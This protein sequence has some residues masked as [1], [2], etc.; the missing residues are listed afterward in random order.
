MSGIY[1]FD[2]SQNLYK[3]VPD[4]MIIDN[5]QEQELNGLISGTCKLK[6]S[7]DLEDAFFYG[8]K[9]EDK[10]WLFSIKNAIKKENTITFKGVHIMYDELKGKVVRDLRPNNK[11]VGSVCTSIL[12]GTGWECISHCN[13]RG[14]TNFYYQSSLS[15]LY[16]VVQKFGV[17]FVPVVKFS[18]GKIVAKQIHI[19]SKLG[20]DLGKVFAYKDNLVQVVAETSSDELFTAFIGRGKGETK[21][22]DS[23]KATGGYGRKIKFDSIDYKDTIDDI[24]VHSPIGSDMIEIKEATKIYGYPDGSPRICTVDFDDIEDKNELAIATFKFAI[25]HSRPR[26][27]LRAKGHAY[28]RIGIGEIVTIIGPMD[29]RFKTRIFKLKKDFL[30]KKI[31]DFE[32]GDKIVKSMSD[33]LKENQ[34]DSKV[35]EINEI[36]FMDSIFTMIEST[37]YNED[38]YQY[39]LKPG[40]KYKLPAGLYSFNKPIDKNPDKVIYFGAGKLMIANSKKDDGSW[41][42]RVALN[43]DSVNADEIRAGILRGGKV[44]WN[45]EDGTFIIGND[46]TDY[47]MY[48]DGST[49]HL[50]NVDIDLENNRTIQDLKNKQGM[51]DKEIAARKE[52]IESAK[53]DLQEA[54]TSL[55]GSISEVSNNVGDLDNRLDKQDEK[56]KI[57]SK[58]ILD[59]KTNLKITDGKIQTSVESINKTVEEKIHANIDY[60]DGKDRDL[61]TYLNNN[62]ST[63]SQTDDKISSEVGK[64]QI[65]TDEK[66]RLGDEEVRKY[67]TKNYTTITQTDEKIEAT[68][69]SFKDDMS[70]YESRFTQLK[71]EISLEVSSSKQ[72]GVYKNLIKYGWKWEYGQGIYWYSDR[73]DNFVARG[74]SYYIESN[75]DLRFTSNKEADTFTEF[76]FEL[77]E[78][79]PGIEEYTLICE[80]S[81]IKNTVQLP[82]F[83][84]DDKFNNFL[85]YGTEINKSDKVYKL[86]L[87]DDN[88]NNI[89]YQLRL[90]FKD[91]Q[92]GTDKDRSIVI[93]Q[94]KLALVKGWHPNLTWDDIYFPN[95]QGIEEVRSELKVQTDKISASVSDKVKGLESKI[96]I[97]ADRITSKVS[98]GD[99]ISEIN[100]SPEQ[101]KIKASKIDLTGNVNVRG[102]FTTYNFANNIGVEMRY[103]RI[104]WRDDRWENKTFG[105]INVAQD[106]YNKEEYSFNIGHYATGETIISY[107]KDPYWRPYVTFDRWNYTG[108]G[109][110]AHPVCFNEGVR[111]QGETKFE[112]IIHFKRMR[113]RE[114]DGGIAL[115]NYNGNGLFISTSGNV[116]IDKGGNRYEVDVK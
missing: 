100:Q 56:N 59:L 32:F 8:V 25:E 112:N 46:P 116:Y 87:T 84:L 81:E 104:S 29:I 40:N 7:S 89:P 4:K 82:Q 18:D 80:P 39:D 13:V 47:S 106:S 111:F 78:I 16:K 26:V 28:E 105:E 55:E 108:D 103:N 79:E 24:T 90:S 83:R 14:S 22:D 114:Y 48:W 6:Y 37:Y 27:Q 20:E 12:K 99:V 33:R 60:I 17:D 63:I 49:L 65:E 3:T 85:C 75:G 50:R 97:Q 57:V 23:G 115:E 96:S 31:L 36:S 68:V 107:Y 102:S 9:D 42:F 45:L 61:R 86:T 110:A 72:S 35:D 77:I 38:G 58:D 70:K 41:N 69:K 71:D 62:Y 1:I 67:I 91:S 51:T 21:T 30:S 54:K 52:E 11:L 94:R 113:L 73:D 15:A 53:K 109:G 93:P 44:R 98:R 76:S 2:N 10:F 64:I 43:G 66:I 5:Y 19:Y 92:A 101:V 88:Q 34:T 74:G 95:D